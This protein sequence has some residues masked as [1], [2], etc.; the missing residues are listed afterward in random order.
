MCGVQL[1]RAQ[2]RKE[3]RGTNWSWGEEQ[4]SQESKATAL[5]AVL[6]SAGSRIEH[7]VAEQQ[8]C[9]VPTSTQH[10]TNS[11]NHSQQPAAPGFRATPKT[12]FVRQTSF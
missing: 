12:S 2:I 4:E 10:P 11:L 5:R 9:H 1:E 7:A 3:K 6:A 8:Q